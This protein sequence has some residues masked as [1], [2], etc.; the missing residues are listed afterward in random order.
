M[1]SVGGAGGAGGSGPIGPGG[2]VDGPEGVGP[3][4]GAEAAA[5]T[6]PAAATARVDQ[7]AADLD[8]GKITPEQAMAALI[9]E[10]VAGLPPAEQAEVRR[11]M[12]DVVAADPYLGGLLGST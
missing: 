3:A 2:P 9:D 6:S 12:E 11:L 7:L 5:E 1:T 10:S 4:D 8:A